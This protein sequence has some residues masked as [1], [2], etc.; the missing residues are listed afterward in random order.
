[1]ALAGFANSPSMTLVS[2]A[3]LDIGFYF[4]AVSQA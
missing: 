3:D 1:M 4:I 2:H